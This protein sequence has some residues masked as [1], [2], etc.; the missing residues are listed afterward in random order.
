MN[1]LS[2]DLVLNLFT[3]RSEK[4]KVFLS[5]TIRKFYIRSYMYVIRV[6]VFYNGC[7][8]F[9]HLFRNSYS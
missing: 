4:V 5:Y 8:M 9:I 6:D 7:L 2:Y 3:L 1:S